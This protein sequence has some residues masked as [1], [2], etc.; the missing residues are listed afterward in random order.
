MS[1]HPGGAEDTPEPVGST[2][3]NP[4]VVDENGVI[5]TPRRRGNAVNNPLFVDN[6]GNIVTPPRP[7]TAP[8]PG[9]VVDENGHVI[10]IRRS[11]TPLTTSPSGRLYKNH[12]S[13]INVNVVRKRTRAARDE[14]N[15]LPYL[16]AMA[17]KSG[18]PTL[19]SSS[20]TSSSSV[21]GPSH[22][23][24]TS[25]SASASASSS[26][27]SSSSLV[28]SSSSSPAP[29]R[30]AK[31]QLGRKRVITP[32]FRLRR[33]PPL[34]IK[35]LYLTA[36]RPPADSHPRPHH[37]CSI[38]YNIKSH[39]VW[40]R[41]GHSHCYVCVRRWLETS[42]LCPYCKEL[43]QEAPMRN[44]DGENA[45]AFDHPEWHDPS[46]VDYDFDGLR[47]PTVTYV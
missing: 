37:E 17:R 45:I 38:C 33:N 31:K 16:R 39:P 47:F 40:Y 41:C 4:F 32:G 29:S 46:D 35:D 3:N 23:S 11:P 9:A 21:A 22:S 26:A 24:V 19:A 13:L 1:T 15:N 14:A 28:A 42:W 27:S 18:G 6:D 10:R 7:S 36:S 20:A 5:L 44:W 8:P 12:R 2:A 30:K 25:S 43:M 34:T